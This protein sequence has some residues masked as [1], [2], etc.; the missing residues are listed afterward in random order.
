MTD[1]VTL[2]LPRE[3]DFFGVAHLVL[4]G[5][6]A[7]LDLTYDVL[8]DMTTAI[9]ELLQRRDSPE[10]VTLSVEIRDD[11]VV[12]TVG[13]FTGSVAEELRGPNE[14]LGLRRV[15]EATVDDVGLSERD[16]AQWVELKKSL[17]RAE[18]DVG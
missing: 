18:A 6:G 11:A 5:L 7:R 14:G 1:V 12:A 13:P 15:L 2:Q 3:R 9:D 10:D 17:E 16:G 4:G 8:E